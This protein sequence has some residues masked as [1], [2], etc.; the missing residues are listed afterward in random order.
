M[1][2]GMK[3]GERRRKK[4]NVDE[5]LRFALSK[6]QIDPYELDALMNGYEL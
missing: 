5:G 6:Q 3:R 1:G 4:P 2:D